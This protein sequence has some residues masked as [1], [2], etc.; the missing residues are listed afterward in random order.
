M[1]D[2]IELINALTRLIAEIRKAVAASY[3]R[4]RA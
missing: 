3:R 1:R 4:N 2:L